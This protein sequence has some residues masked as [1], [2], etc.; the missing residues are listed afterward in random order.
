MGVEPTGMGS[1]PIRSQPQFPQSSVVFLHQGRQGATNAHSSSLTSPGY[2]LRGKTSS[3]IP[4]AYGVHHTLQN[5]WV[6]SRLGSPSRRVKGLGQ[7]MPRT[8]PTPR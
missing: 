5:V 7:V 6:R 2:S 3:S 4:E 1:T 8:L